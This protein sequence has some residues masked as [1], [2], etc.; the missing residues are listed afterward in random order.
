MGFIFAKR[1]FDK[2]ASK[3]TSLWTI[4]IKDIEGNQVTLDKYRG[5][6]KAFLFVNVACK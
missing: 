3:E 2:L 5:N 6:N 1:G 4:P